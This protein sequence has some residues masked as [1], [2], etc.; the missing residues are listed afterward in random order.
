MWEQVKNYSWQKFVFILL[1][2][3]KS[4]SANLWFLGCSFN[5]LWKIRFLGCPFDL[6]PAHFH[7]EGI[8]PRFPGQ[9]RARWL[10]IL[11]HSNFSRFVDHLISQYCCM[12][13]SNDPRSDVS[14]TLLSRLPQDRDR[15]LEALRKSRWL[16][17]SAFSWRGTPA[18]NLRTDLLKVLVTK[19]FVYHHSFPARNDTDWQQWLPE[20]WRQIWIWFSE[21]STSNPSWSCSAFPNF[22][23][24]YGLKS[25]L[26]RFG[27]EC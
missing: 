2:M 11:S 24:A 15:N 20:K 14:Q 9:K 16:A 12:D 7:N 10:R 26:I 27:I 18:Q 6:L 25:L 21:I 13:Q 8:P 19:F 23:L 17:F 5:L 4:R 3:A 1:S 22:H